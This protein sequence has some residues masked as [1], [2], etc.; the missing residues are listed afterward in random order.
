MK[1]AGTNISGVHDSCGIPDG[2]PAVLRYVGATGKSVNM[3]TD[4]L[5]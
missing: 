5:C 4:G 1:R 2:V 3:G